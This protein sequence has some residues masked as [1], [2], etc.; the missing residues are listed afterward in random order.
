MDFVP[1]L[2]RPVSVKAL[3]DHVGLPEK[4][5]LEY[6]QQWAAKGLIELL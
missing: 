6:L 1:A 5:T 4:E 2:D 3:A